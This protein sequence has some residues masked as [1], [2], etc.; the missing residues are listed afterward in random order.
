[1][2]GLLIPVNCS[3]LLVNNFNSFSFTCNWMSLSDASQLSEYSF[4]CL[5][6]SNLFLSFFIHSPLPNLSKLSLPFERRDSFLNSF[7]SFILGIPLPPSAAVCQIVQLFPASVGETCSL[8]IIYSFQKTTA[9]FAASQRTV[10]FYWISIL[11][12]PSLSQ[13]HKLTKMNRGKHKRER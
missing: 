5:H 4:I 12:L 13:I 7:S 11:F 3:T 6:F 2:V 9:S 10:L 1:M 8:F